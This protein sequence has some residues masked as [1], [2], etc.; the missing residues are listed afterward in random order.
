MFSPRGGSAH[1]TRAFARAL[2]EQ[3]FEVTLLA[4]SNG[5]GV[6][7][8]ARAFYGDVRPV[9]FGPALRSDTPVEFA[10]PPGT[11]PLHPSFEERP[12]APDPVFA[13]LHETVFERHVR[14]W[15][16]ELERAGAADADVLH[17]HHLTPLNEAAARVAPGVPVVGHLHGTE[18]LMLEQIAAGAPPTWAY[19]EQWAERL[20]HWARHCAR[21]V[22]VPAGVERAVDVLAVPPEHVVGVPNGV[23]ADAFRPSRPDR[24][25]FWRRVLVEQPQGWLPGEPPGSVRYDDAEVE[26][27]ADGPVLLHVGR[28]TAVKRLDLLIGA[29]ARAQRQVGGPAGLVLV[30]GHPG[31]W[32]GEHPAELA[33]RLGADGVFLAGW[34]SQEALPEF[35]SAADAVV[36]ASDREQF[37]Q[38]LLQGMA[39]ARPAVAVDSLGPAEIIADGRTGWL[40]EPEEEALAAALVEVL[41]NPGELE[42][43]GRA[44][45]EDV[46]RRYTWP[47]V[48]AQ[49]AEVLDAASVSTRRGAAGV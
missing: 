19:A 6:E 38:V 39:C 45:R 30:G 20:R 34:H 13:S 49:L 40:V 8:D 16:R 41:E 7:G 46:S 32:E 14:A 2:R 24:R 36:L 42:R 9:D 10:G 31:E 28:F 48:A 21:L 4:G 5:D 29:F 12:D 25:S 1:V 37:G 22:I 11:A 35:F 17:L 23:D 27:L 3:G 43:R 33:A 15:A 47:R 26:R 44:A 18:L